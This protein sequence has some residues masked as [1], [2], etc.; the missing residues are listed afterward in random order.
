METSVL[1]SVNGCFLQHKKCAV[2][3]KINVHETSQM[4]CYHLYFSFIYK[5]SIVNF[6]SIMQVTLAAERTGAGGFSPL[7]HQGREG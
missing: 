1:K 5:F 2:I 6:Y 4:K 3:G 7:I